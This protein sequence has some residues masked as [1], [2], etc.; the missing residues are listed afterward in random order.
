VHG[1]VSFHEGLLLRVR[2]SGA[3]QSILP[4]TGLGKIR[5]A[6]GYLIPHET[7]CACDGAM[8]SFFRTAC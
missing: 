8:Q 3:M 6:L 7:L 2:V 4:T 1:R 5:V